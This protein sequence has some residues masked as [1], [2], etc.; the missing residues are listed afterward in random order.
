MGWWLGCLIDQTTTTVA[1]AAIGGAAVTQRETLT[2]RPSLLSTATEELEE[3][4][5]EARPIHP[6]IKHHQQST[7]RLSPIQSI[8]R[9]FAA[10]ILEKRPQTVPNRLRAAIQSSRSSRGGGRR[11][12]L[13]VRRELF[14]LGALAFLLLSAFYVSFRPGP[15]F[16]AHRRTRRPTTRLQLFL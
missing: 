10:G 1:W 12:L 15:S 4:D 6:L 16:N 11:R 14:K 13:F 2:R 9:L 8:G 3:I 7:T 5:P